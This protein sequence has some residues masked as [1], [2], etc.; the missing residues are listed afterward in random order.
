MPPPKTPPNFFSNNSFSGLELR[1][2]FN[3]LRDIRYLVDDL[4]QSLI[5]TAELMCALERRLQQDFFP[6]VDGGHDYPFTED[7]LHECARVPAYYALSDYVP[8]TTHATT[9]LDE[10]RNNLQNYMGF[11][12]LESDLLLYLVLQTRG[13]IPN[14]LCG[15]FTRLF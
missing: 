15:S 2:D 14:F 12:V 6:C 8:S 3:A 4:L 13:G 5:L 10:I 9:V 11:S 1:V 7:D